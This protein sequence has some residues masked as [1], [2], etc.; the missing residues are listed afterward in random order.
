MDEKKRAQMY[1]ECQ[2]IVRLESGLVCFAVADYL[3]A[4]STKLKGLT[5]SGRYDLADLRIPEKGW[6]A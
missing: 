3:D 5:I 2:S 1:A 4:A 6:F